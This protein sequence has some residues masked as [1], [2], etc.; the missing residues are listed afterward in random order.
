MNRLLHLVQHFGKTRGLRLNEEKC[1]HLR[2]N[3][4]HN[5]FY[6]PSCYLVCTCPLC[7]AGAALGEP[8]PVSDEI[9]YLGVFL[10]STSSNS[11]NTRNRVS[12]AITAS[13]LLKPL[14][15]HG[16]L[17][18]SWKLQVYPSIVQAILMYAMDGVLV[19]PPQII[20]M[21]AVHFKVMRSIFGFKSSY[22]HRVIAPTDAPYS[23]EFLADTS[24]RTGRVITPSQLYSQCRLQLLGHLMRH[25]ESLEYQA[26]FM[27]SG[28]YR[29]T[30]GSN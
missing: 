10:D 1:Q 2:L 11:K 25:P 17:P 19:S 16:S 22:Y 21:N 20:K 5:V 15:A 26:T 30:R 3:S 7:H 29:F 18:S 8:V 27:T 24:F 28:A 13:K 4:D 14:M 12:K 9:K 6:S 23:S